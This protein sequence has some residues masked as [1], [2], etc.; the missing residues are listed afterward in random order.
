MTT[1]GVEREKLKLLQKQLALS[2]KSV[3][4]EARPE[5]IAIVGLHGYLPQAMGVQDFWRYLDEDRSVITEIPADRFDWREFY[6]ATGEDASKM[7][8]RWGAFIPDIKS[9]DPAF[10]G[11]LPNEADLLDP[12]LR[13]LLMSVYQSLENAGCAPSGL[14]KSRT[15]VYVAL[16][17]NEYLHHL[18]AARVD[19]GVNGFNHHPSMVA[20]RLSYFFDLR[21]PSEIVNT[22]CASGAVA[23][24]RAM[25][26]IH[27]REIDLA[28]V[29]AARIILRPEPLIGLSRMKVLSSKDS[30][31]SFGED[32]EG[33]IRAEGVISLVLKPLS[34]AQ[35][36]HD[37]IHA[38]IRS[39][40]VN[41]NG[42]GGMSIAAPNVEAHTEVIKRCYEQAGVDARDIGYIE[43]QGM[44]NQVGDIS[45]WEACNR[46]L[47]QLASAQGNVIEPGSCRISTLKPMLGHMECASALGAVLKIVRT[48]QTQKVHKI[49]GLERVNP[50]L[51]L[52]GR[53]CRLMT[54]T[55]PWTRGQRPRLAG[56]HSY[57]SGGNNA[58][59]L[60]EEYVPSSRPVV[61]PPARRQLLVV[62]GKTQLQLREHVAALRDHLEREPG[63]PLAN[64]AFTLQTGRDALAHRAAFVVGS[65]AEFVEKAGAFLGASKELP[66][67][68]TG[69]VKDP[70]SPGRG[71]DTK[72]LDGTAAAWVSG[73]P[74]DW[75]TLHEGTDV[76][77]VTLPAYAF[78]KVPCWASAPRQQQSE[79]ASAPRVE[80]VESK[81][82]RS[83]GEKRPKRI[84][85]VGA[86]PSGL[87]MAKSLLEEGHQP[88]IFEK[89][90]TMGGL[91]VLN[92]EKTA[93]A[94]KKTRFQSSMFTSIFSDFLPQDIKSTFY[95]VDE[96]MA[97]LRRYA[98]AFH[99]TE[100]IQ[101]ESEVVSV[102]QVGDRWTVTIRRNGEERQEEFDGVA[103]CQ[104]SFWQPYFPKKKGLE[105]FKGEILHSGQYFDNSSFRGKRV[106]VIGSG[107]S[108][109]D[110]AEEAAEVA[111]EVYW[112]R[113]SKKLILPRMVGFVP[114][115]C[116]S[117]ASLLIPENRYNIIERLRQSMPE[118]FELYQRSGIL[119]SEQ[120]FRRNPIV[121]INDGIVKLVAEGKVQPRGDLERFY[122]KGCVFSD[123][124]SSEVEVDVVVFATGYKNFGSEDV[125]YGYLQNISVAKEF[126]MG[127]FYG[128]NPSLVNTSVLP[129]AFTGS[130]YF[131]E[132]VARWYA[133][134]MSGKYVLSDEELSHRITDDYYLIMAP[135]S[136]VL[137]GLKLGLFPRPEQEFREFWRLLNYPAFPMIHRLRGSH[138]N[139]DAR[140]QLEVFRQKSFVKTDQ[141]DPA[142]KLLKHRILA[143]LGRENLESLL[144]RGEITSAEYD[145]ALEQ[146][147]NPLVLDWE[148]QYIKKK[149]R[150]EAGPG[151]LAAAAKPEAV[152]GPGAARKVEES[153]A[154]TLAAMTAEVLRVEPGEIEPEK[155]L[156]EYGF[157][158]ITLTGFSN[159]LS[160]QFRF[161]KL[162]P[163]TFL[164]HPT[165]GALVG[166]L[167]RKYGKE[168][169]E[170]FGLNEVETTAQPVVAKVE[171]VATE[172]RSEARAPTYS[173]SSGTESPESDE[174]IAIIG[175]GGRFPGA[176]SVSEF[177]RNL[178]DERS[179]ISEVPDSR[180]RWQDY[181]GDPQKEENKTDCTHGAFLEGIDRFDPLHFD[182]SPREATFMDPQHRML[183]EVTWETMENA[184]Y[185]RAR[186][187]NKRVGLFVGVEKQDYVELL[188]DSG[189][190]LDG[191]M[192]T[193]NAHSMLANRV[194]RYF[195]WRGPS[196]VLDTACSG[197]FTALSLAVEQLRHGS[198]ELAFVGGVNVLLTPSLFILNRKLGMLTNE[199]VTRP[200]DRG[201]SGHLNGEGMG[202]VLLKRLSSAIRDNDTIYGVIKGVAVEH[203]GKGV[204][205]MAPNA[206]SHQ[207]V[208]REALRDARLQ[209]G[210]IDYI[211]A[212]GTGNQLTDVMELKTY[213]H[214]FSARPSGAIGLGTIKGNLGHLG[215]ASGVVGLIKSVLSLRNN[216][217]TRILNLQE[218]NWD[219][220]D[221]ELPVRVLDR[222][223]AWPA[224]YQGGQRVPRR[225]GIHNYGFGGM[226]AHAILEEYVDAGRPAQ[227]P[228]GA[229]E[230]VIVL[231]T[232]KAPQ[233]QMLARQLLRFLKGQEYLSWGFS[234]ITLEEVAFALQ[235]GR[236][237]MTHRVAFVASSLPDLV[238]K[239]ERYLDDR[240]QTETSGGGI[241]RGAVDDAA[242]KEW[243]L[244]LGEEES[245]F[246]I[247]NSLQR[248]NLAKLALLW[249]KGVQIPWEELY[250]SRRVRRVPLPGYPFLRERYWIPPGRAVRTV[251]AERLSTAMI[252]APPPQVEKGVD[253]DAGSVVVGLL[254]QVTAIPREQLTGSAVL[255][256]QGID[257]MLT[258][259]LVDLIDSTL[260]VR[261]ELSDV[262][263]CQTVGE[264]VQRV[265]SRGESGSSRSVLP[266]EVELLRRGD[267]LASTVWFHAA[268]G[269]VQM[270]VPFA[271]K[272]GGDLS[273]HAVQSR[274]VRDSQKPFDDLVEMAS[275]YRDILMKLKGQ[276][277]FQ[278]GGYS[279]G[280]ALAYEVARQLQL[281]GRSVTSIVLVDTPFPPVSSRISR[282]CNLALTF[283]NIL[284]MSGL[285]RPDD[286]K[287]FMARSPRNED[288]LPFLV[289]VGLERG[290]KYSEDELR[291]AI[292]KFSAISEAN[293]TSMGRYS[294]APLPRPGEV[295]CHYFSRRDKEWFFRPELATVEE[296]A[297]Q[298]RYHATSDCVERWRDF[299][300][301]L[302]VHRT[303]A[304]DHFAMFEDEE[305]LGMMVEVCRR[306]YGIEPRIDA[307]AMLARETARDSTEARS[308]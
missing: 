80:I 53:P 168:L 120:E 183:L 20:N 278:L 63:V 190:A 98:E 139:E 179:S 16:E 279:Q 160:R 154:R 208:I 306:L 198:I 60:L 46:A 5:P 24:H 229:A 189:H 184:G 79:P 50:Y 206:T 83:T 216:T 128:K 285:A 72:E 300:P 170:H 188:K 87:V 150:D 13:L 221:G 210:D 215:A 218:L 239:L 40:A 45:E 118:Y 112:S 284:N 26:A 115:D 135:V 281:A 245:R 129:I 294:V 116:Q 136:S 74:V 68:H 149:S 176:A 119:P 260:S 209:P 137:F 153:L 185:T 291:A 282:K 243:K 288:L 143:G 148:A 99:L 254:A 12:Q 125:R 197:S 23:I 195:S 152:T 289:Q 90:R 267:G 174:A 134:I 222:T 94:Y 51:D 122:E 219:E 52:E 305:T 22:M 110:I 35:R 258:A 268:L 171:V 213:Q 2:R 214:V 187:Q 242:L 30:V 303:A 164:E 186:L 32:A 194:S 196:M 201:A 307:A 283:L 49:L 84:C 272:L 253:K 31:K 133:Q 36:D 9:F 297:E 193:G 166:F 165:L 266:R 78:K 113:R 156:S 109:M 43:A 169:R 27:N 77:K 212:Q 130:F 234:E 56:L 6:D 203:G 3:H 237:A 269:T 292:Q 298:N 61:S 238:E 104:G 126:A 106:L 28:I 293:I 102:S 76:E 146:R 177:W 290:L 34:K 114:N 39:S 211:E 220:A 250:G 271:R 69:V 257:S 73:A 117:P 224:K 93:G 138:A 233:L 108:A 18:R 241:F 15:G 204:Y 175:I 231:S 199:P 127:I 159:E 44:G 85:V 142:L 47:E 57:G 200:F 14:K 308:V 1:V 54:S 261:L 103:L 10:F 86:G 230:Q 92:K 296:L 155:N 275:H 55:E 161:I 71:L 167:A 248:R 144:R 172:A 246:I 7:R 263:E 38:L 124:A 202:L 192:N 37:R 59:L 111:A 66:G 276:G 191:Y 223:E 17:D 147:A 235:C 178:V 228:A 151:L 65:V 301:N 58:H 270:Y 89:Q 158:S 217:L 33:Y 8:T 141:S 265:R 181:W 67:V 95:S 62:S 101:Y 182:I 225:V 244:L 75:A 280:G 19:L 295:E 162:A 302:T 82:P 287:T 205:L 97:Y 91:W 145:G 123:A 273:F 48:F 107:V 121:H 163:S 11:F 264:L 247:Q 180:W 4:E 252:E 299:L 100:L 21:G 29:G 255:R 64:V 304:P 259:Q 131:M 25:T 226:N 286:L 81:A 236:E 256:E 207:E 132:M 251:A 105:H 88:V 157:D 42:Q 240:G 227:T 262:Q 70:V 96:V 249:V 140:K 41:Y 274:G 277:A 173:V 232:R